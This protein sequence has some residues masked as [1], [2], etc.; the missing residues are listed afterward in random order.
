MSRS[1]DQLGSGDH[2]PCV[3]WCRCHAAEVELVTPQ[4]G[5]RYVEVTWEH[6]GGRFRDR[7]YMTP[8]TLGRLAAVV[9]RL[10]DA[11][12]RE[13]PDD[14]DD[15]VAELAAVIC[16]QIVGVMADVQ[17]VEQP[18][19]QGK[20]RRQVSFAGYRAAAAPA[21]SRPRATDDPP[22][23]DGPPDDEE[24]GTGMDDACPF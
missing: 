16:E 7:L 15:A 24:R 19:R 3:G 5:T 14:D 17:V 21:A 20:L 4:T 22:P 6:D 11:A 18:D 8:K 10:C 13:W 2:W 23:V 9:Q 1:L 12:G